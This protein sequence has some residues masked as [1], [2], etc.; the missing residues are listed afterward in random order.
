[1][2]RATISEKA[3]LAL[4]KLSVYKDRMVELKELFRCELRL[5][6]ELHPPIFEYSYLCDYKYG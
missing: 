3:E 1:M 2:G 4:Q 5:T 6:F